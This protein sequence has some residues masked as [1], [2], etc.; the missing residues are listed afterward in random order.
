MII[1]LLACSESTGGELNDCCVFLD[2]E[3]T[4]VERLEAQLS[5]RPQERGVSHGVCRYRLAGIDVPCLLKVLMKDTENRKRDGNSNGVAIELFEDITVEVVVDSWIEAPAT[6][7]GIF[8]SGFGQPIGD[9]PLNAN[10]TIHYREDGTFFAS[11]SLDADRAFRIE[12]IQN[13]NLY[14]VTEVNPVDRID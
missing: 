1:C 6:Y 3:D 8:T 11:I 12:S 13:S 9:Y 2:A 14:K 5:E 10:F 7:G 4:E